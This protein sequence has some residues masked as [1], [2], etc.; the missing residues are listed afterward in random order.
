MNQLFRPLKVRDVTIRNRVGISP[1]CQYSSED[2][3]AN[4]WH[5]VHLG[6]RAVGGSGLVIAEATAVEARGRIS[7]QDAGLWTDDQIEPLSRINRFVEAHGAVP[8]IQLAHAGRKAS[9]SRPW[10]GDRHLKD[11]EGGWPIVGPSAIA[12][13]GEL[14]KV[15]SALSVSEI[16]GI[17]ASFVASARRAIAAGYKVLELHYAHGYLA[18][19]FYS[20]L[21]NQRTD[22]YGGSFEN[23]I[24]FI[25]ETTQAVRAVWPERLPLF[26]RLAVVDFQEGGV[27][28]E[29]SI[30][31]AKR[32]K[33]EGLDLLDVS[34]GF[35][36]P[37]VSG[38]PWGPGFM[39]PIAG[40][41]K[42]EAGIPTAASWIITEP[43]QAEAILASGELDLVLLARASL[44]DPHW[45]YHAAESLGES[46]PQNLLPTQYTHWLNRRRG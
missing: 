31:L 37:D 28:V 42:R 26:A 25:M 34:F 19:S 15:P 10:E 46:A 24:R 3:K 1:M 12:F 8:G 32:L 35:N 9:A 43:A 41:I 40:R 16:H 20:P 4:D 11:E 23:R 33:G 13:G 21:A 44:G 14:W 7:P 45:A 30:E 38:V 2:G 29:E 5:L 39:A 17:R 6:A 18:N 36:T 27:T 22:E